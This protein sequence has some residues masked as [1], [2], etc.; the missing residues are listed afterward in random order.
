MQT[1]ARGEIVNLQDVERKIAKLTASDPELKRFDDEWNQEYEIR[2]MLREA[3]E[4][5]GVSQKR[6]GPSFKR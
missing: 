2:K 5:A 4:E 1:A 6:K 3:R